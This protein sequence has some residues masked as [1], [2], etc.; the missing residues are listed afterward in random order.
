M[1][2]NISQRP[3]FTLVELLVT[4]GIILMLVTLAVAFIPQVQDRARTADGAGVLQSQLAIAKQ[5]A[6]KDGLVSGIRLSFDP[7]T[8]WVTQL[9]HITQ[10]RDLIGV[11]PGVTALSPSI[12]RL[13]FASGTPPTATLEPPDMGWTGVVNDFS[14]GQTDKTL[15]QVQSGDYLEV[16]WSDPTK[17]EIFR[18]IDLSPSATTLSL[19]PDP[20]ATLLTSP[21]D[22]YRFFRQPRP[23]IGETPL[24][25]PDKIAIDLNTNVT[26]G[27]LPATITSPI[28]ILFTPT[29]VVYHWPYPSDKLHLWVRDTTAG[30]IFDRAQLVTVFVRTGLIGGFP[31]GDSATPYQNAEKGKTS[32]L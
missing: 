11:T 20:L 4:L 28:D 8:K 10:E 5:Y 23:R 16:A 17:H 7:T 26:Y 25:L 13:V 27:N 29:G 19:Y 31:L 21:V 2:Q 30:S 24:S 1:I 3:A 12:R 6:K 9:Q 15:W 22:Q 32:G 14:G 18:V